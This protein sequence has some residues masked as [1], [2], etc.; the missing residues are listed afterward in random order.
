MRSTIVGLDIE[1]K[2]VKLG[3]RVHFVRADQ[4][5]PGELEAAVRMHGVPDVVIDDGSHV[6]DHIWATFEH[7]WPMLSPGG[8]YVIE[9]L[10][11][12]YYP[13]FGGGNPP[14]PSSA[15]ALV[16]HLVDSVQAQDSTFARKPE[17]GSR[18]AP[19]FPAVQA[20]HTHPGIV[21]IEKGRNA[22]TP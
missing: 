17:W 19:R 13:R 3:S 11:T 10:S 16:A 21:F 1:Q 6:G 2:A 5:E 9:D 20:V 4:S 22:L 18:L 15:V 8:V 12:S 14:P 7:L